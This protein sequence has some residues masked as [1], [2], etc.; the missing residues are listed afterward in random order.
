MTCREMPTLGSREADP[1]NSTFPRQKNDSCQILENEHKCLPW[2]MLSI[3]AAVNLAVF[4]LT[5]YRT[6][7]KRC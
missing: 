3:C 4:A 7:A 2:S 5:A 1:S 6:T